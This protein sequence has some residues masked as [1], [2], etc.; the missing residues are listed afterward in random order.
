M[1]NIIIGNWKMNNDVKASKVFFKET[2]KLIESNK[3]KI[4]CEYGIAPTFTSLAIMSQEDRGMELV[5]QNA[6]FEKSGA[7]TGE[8]SLDMLK[9]LNVNYVIL[10]HSERREIFKECNCNINKKVLATLANGQ[11]PILCIGETLEQFEAKETKE[12]V[13]NQLTKGLKDVKANELEKVVIAYEPIWAIGTGKTAT[14]E[15]A[16][17]V[18]K[19]IRDEVRNL[20]GDIA[21]KVR[22]QY[23]G[24]VKPDNVDEI[25]SQE[26]INGAL[27]GG[28]SLQPESFVKLLTLNK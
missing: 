19:Y 25:L 14:A 13:K 18:C 1:K 4:D 21:D 6:S 8:I 5:A 7:F 9:E 2:K 24:S 22:I 11:K 28:A 26:D 23:G 17:N 20:F 12:I 16:Q 10:G 15:I 27:V 3:D